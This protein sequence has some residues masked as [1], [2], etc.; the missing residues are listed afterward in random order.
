MTID[1]E[2]A[3]IDG[4]VDDI[5]AD[6]NELQTD[7]VN[8]GRLDLIL[9][10]AASGGGGGGG[11]DAAGVRSA[12]GLASANLDTQLATIDANV[13]SILEDTGTT[14]PASLATIDGNVDDI[15][16]DTGTT[17]PATL[18]TIDDEIAVIDSNVDLVLEDT[19]TTLPATLATIDKE[20]AAIDA[21]VDSI[22]EDTG[23]T[24]PATL[25]TIDNEI[26]AM[27]SN[28]DAILVDTGTTLPATLA[29]IDGIVDDI[30]VDTNSTIPAQITALNDFDPASDI[31][32]ANMT[33]MLGTSLTGSTIPGN[34]Q[35]FFANG[36]SSTAKTVDDVGGGGTSGGT[37][38]C[39]LTEILGTSISESAAGRIAGNWDEFW[40]NGNIASTSVVSDV[41]T[42]T[43]SGE[44]SAN[45]TAIKGSQLTET[46]ASRLADNFSTLFDNG[47]APST[48]TQ[49]DIGSATVSSTVDCNL[50]EVLGTSITQTSTGRAA[51]NWSTL[52][53]NNDQASTKLLSDI[54]TAVVTGQLT[55]NVTQVMG[56]PLSETSAA[57]LADNISQFFDL[58]TTTTKTVNDVDQA[59]VTGTVDA[60]LT[61]ILSTNITESS[62][63]RIAENW[64]NL[65]DNGDVLSAV[66]LQTLQDIDDSITNIA[67]AGARTVTVNVK[68]TAAS[69]VNLQNAKIRL[70]EGINSFTAS[71]DAYGNA[72]FGLDDATYSY[73]ITKN[74]YVSETGTI[75]VTADATV[76]KDIE[77][78]TITGSSGSDTSTGVL[79]CYD[80]NYAAE[81]GV[82]FSVQMTVGPGV[83]GD[84]LDTKVR[85]ADSDGAGLVQFTNLIRGATYQIWRSTFTSSSVFGSVATA[86]AK[87]TF[88]VPDSASFDLPEV[89]GVDDE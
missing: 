59:T 35:T 38:D 81:S 39:N 53:D 18:T 82:T 8:G 83:A 79:T 62:S 22:L 49:D 63:G 69:P 45:L 19:G 15:L 61:S 66:T 77:Q 10:T 28:V 7:W 14:L 56:S 42:A 9:D 23:T 47:N 75:V 12:I 31:V 5:L 78:S 41:G 3:T 50:V 37:I 89:L 68:D 4:N 85:T 16:E 48:K 86:N 46:S 58:D 74:G 29:T 57:N 30:L 52:Y 40:D 26:A 71:T 55:A 34:F 60:N 54:G 20:I 33:Q 73:A 11:L 80:E 6:T 84:A 1:N 25:S 17:I 76:N 65:F 21:K 70:T 67:G 36:S 13:D 72:V 24:L 44:I 88:V 43:V 27:D 51:Q 2:I 87:V 64:D 32:L